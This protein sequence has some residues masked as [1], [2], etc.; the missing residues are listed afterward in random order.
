KGAACETHGEA[1]RTGAGETERRIHESE[2]MPMVHVPRE[3]NAPV[4]LRAVVL[5]VGQAKAGSGAAVGNLYLISRLPH[6]DCFKFQGETMSGEGSLVGKREH[7]RSGD[8][9]DGKPAQGTG[10]AGGAAPRM[11]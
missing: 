9:H 5:N 2:R 10:Q 4:N 11:V 3:L 7:A 6:D 8:G 1:E